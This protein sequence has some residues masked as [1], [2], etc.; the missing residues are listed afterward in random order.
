MSALRKTLRSPAEYLAI[1]RRAETQ[2]EYFAGE[3]VVVA[4]AVE[5]H[6]IIASSLGVSF[7]SN[8]RNAAAQLILSTCGSKFHLAF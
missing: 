1:E 5:C 6:H 3:I 2:S 8:S 7:G 4:G